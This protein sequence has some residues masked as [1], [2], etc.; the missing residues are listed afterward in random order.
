VL[1]IGPVR[2]YAE[3]PNDD[4]VMLVVYP[5]VDGTSILYDDDGLTFDHRRGEFMKVQVAWQEASRRLTLQLARGS[6]MVPPNPRRFEV[7]VAGTSVTKPIV[8]TGQSVVVHM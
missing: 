3:E 7:R 1:P 2:Q 5:G 6:R 8:F 4:P